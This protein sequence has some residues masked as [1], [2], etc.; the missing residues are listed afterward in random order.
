M[1]T[2]TKTEARLAGSIV[3][4]IERRRQVN[5][6]LTRLSKRIEANEELKAAKEAEAEALR[7]GVL[8]DFTPSAKALLADLEL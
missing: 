4:K 3:Q 7:A 6:T 1:N 2:L 8:P 5:A